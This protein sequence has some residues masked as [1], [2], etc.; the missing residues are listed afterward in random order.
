ME[1]VVCGGGEALSPLL[2]GGVFLHACVLVLYLDA[3]TLEWGE[4]VVFLEGS[5]LLG[6]RIPLLLLLAASAKA[7]QIGRISITR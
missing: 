3:S 5:V 1:E 2:A 6:G 7:L 4:I